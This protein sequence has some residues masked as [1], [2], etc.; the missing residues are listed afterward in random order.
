MYFKIS[1]VLLLSIANK[2]NAIDSST[3][4]VNNI[5]LIGPDQYY[6]FWNYT[7]T[8]ITFKIVVKT[9]GWVGFGVS[10]N[11]AM[12]YSDVVIAYKNSDGSVNF[13][14]RHATDMRTVLID[15][16]QNAFLLYYS[17]ENGFTTVIFTRKLKI[18]NFNPVDIPIDI[19]PGPQYLVYAWGTNLLNNNIRYHGSN[20]SSTSIPLTNVLNAKVNYNSSEIETVDYTV[21]VSGPKLYT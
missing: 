8:D 12:E 18:C 15:Q 6:L 7:S 10:P 20:R 3:Y 4:F 21:N 16:I 5:T 14:D 17:Q 2:L 9:T 13:T 19:N 1:I 11:G